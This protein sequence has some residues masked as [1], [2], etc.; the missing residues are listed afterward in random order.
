[1]IRACSFFMNGTGPTTTRNRI[2]PND[3]N[4]EF[5]FTWWADFNLI[6]SEQFHGLLFANVV[7]HL[8]FNLP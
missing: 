1:M 4:S 5:N 7:E 8:L 6:L 3:P 2:K